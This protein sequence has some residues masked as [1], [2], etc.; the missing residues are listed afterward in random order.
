MINRQR[1]LE[2]FYELVKIDSP[3]RDERK[4]A[5]RLKAGLE[6]LNLTVSEDNAGDVIGGNCGNVFGYLKGNIP[7]APVILL[8]A[9]MD[10][11]EPG[12]G[13]EPLLKNGLITSSGNT[14][15][16]ADN[17]SGIVPILEALR[18][19]QEHNIPHG[20]IQVVF[21]VAEEGGLNGSRNLDQDLLKADIGFV[22]DAEGKPGKITLSAPGQ[23][24]IKVSVQGKAA[25][26]GIAPEDGISAILVASNAITEMQLGRID[27][28]T[29]ANIG[30]IHGGLATNIVA[31]QVKITC[32]ARS[33]ILSK[34]ERQTEH[35]I[36]A[37]KKSAQSMGAEI[38]IEVKRAYNPFS[39]RSDSQVARVAS[40]A[41]QNLGL[42]PSFIST[43][44]GS[45]ANY[46]NQYG[47]PSA[48]LGIGIQKF[49]TV[50][51]YIEEEDLYQSA[52][53]VVEI[54]KE[55]GRLRK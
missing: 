50:E 44:G 10:T 40:Q 17:K 49:H 34:L 35:M 12:R 25:H 14:I 48:V 53:W 23:D 11:V 20:D 32:E 45:D 52:E 19:I 54:I 28:E 16:G 8:S 36:Q 33:R 42:E 27:E 38:S 21:C 39:L 13:I 9:H 29:T 3:T 46:F 37:F 24:S 51:E 55:V 41:A 1:V 15:L 22:L 6:A 7:Q 4:V 26:A 43:G 31:E 2:E 18:I 30:T 5:D 47:V